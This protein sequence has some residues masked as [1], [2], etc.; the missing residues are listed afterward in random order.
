MASF[1]AKKCNRLNFQSELCG[2]PQP[3]GPQPPANEILEPTMGAWGLCSHWGPGAE[4]LVRSQGT[5]PPPLKL[6]AFYPWHDQKRGKF[7]PL[8]MILG[9]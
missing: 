7:A 9:K 1:L 5:K 8:M 6:K 2:H 3:M 4:P